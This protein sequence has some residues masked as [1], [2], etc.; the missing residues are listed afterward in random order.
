MDVKKCRDEADES[1][2]D[3][4]TWACPYVKSVVERV[5]L[6]AKEAFVCSD[7]VERVWRE[8]SG[9]VDL[10]KPTTRWDWCGLNLPK[11]APKSTE[12]NG[13]EPIVIRDGELEY[14]ST[15]SS[16]FANAEEFVNSKG[17]IPAEMKKAGIRLRVIS[18]DE[19][20]SMGVTCFSLPALQGA[21]NSV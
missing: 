18:K 10:T 11:P 1:E 2:R 12:V 8:E 15:P 14:I 17:I 19:A 3:I 16:R 6:P 7:M 21:S 4:S 20:K 5:A 13:E 9:Q